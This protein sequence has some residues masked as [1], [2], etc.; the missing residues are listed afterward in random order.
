ML[1]ERFVCGRARS[2]AY[3]FSPSE[4]DH[5]ALLIDPGPGAAP[6]VDDVVRA[7]SLEPQA[8]LL[9]H[10]HPDHI[11]AAREVSDRY[12]IPVFVHPSDDGWFDDP[13]TGRHL[14][15]VRLAGLAYGRTKR[16]RPARLERVTER[17][18][19]VGDVPIEVLPTPGHTRGSVCLRVGDVCFAGDTVFRGGLGHTSYPG[20][21]RRSLRES[22]RAALLPLPDDLRL[23]PGHGVETTVGAERPLWTDF[24]GR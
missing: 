24:V 13:A 19:T 14:R 22:I 7:E 23:L 3:V 6:R 8:V 2:N 5:R 15:L 18:L 1:L 20:G 4:S 11:W 10:G 9:T 12:E 21:S 16:L 17:R